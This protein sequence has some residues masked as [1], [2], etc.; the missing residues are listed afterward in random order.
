MMKERLTVQK[1]DAG[2]RLSVFL[3]GRF[4]RIGR[5]QIDVAMHK[6]LVMLNGRVATENEAVEKGDIIELDLSY[7]RTPKIFPE[8]IQLDIRYEDEHLLVLVKPAGMVCHVGLGNYRGT[9]LNALKAYFLDKGEP[10][11]ENGLVHRLDKETEGLMLAA[12]TKQAV[13]EL[14]QMIRDNKVRR[15]YMALVSGIPDPRSGSVALA[16]GRDPDNPNIIRTFPE[17]SGAKAALTHYEVVGEENGNAWVHCTLETGRTHQV[18]IHLAGLGHPVIGD[19]RYGKA[20]EGEKLMLFSSFLEFIHPFT[21]TSLS[22]T[23]QIP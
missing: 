18:R 12:K 20:S 2:K 14:T 3:S 17:G 16:I 7:F 11:I 22:F 21:G 6:G 10:A 13:V 4:K 9:L 15:E 23:Y 1:P 19:R 5:Q 8:K